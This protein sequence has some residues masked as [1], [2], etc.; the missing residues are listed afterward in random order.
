MAKGYDQNQERLAALNWLG[1]DLARR[2]KSKCELCE[3]SGTKLVPY[4]VP[5]VAK[6]P[7]LEKTLLVCEECGSQLTSDRQFRAD[8]RWRVLCTTV[9]GEL[10]AAQVVSVRLLRR[11]AKEPSTESWAYDA[12]EQ[13]YLDPAVEEW[14]DS[15]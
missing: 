14:V 8:D 3:A 15:A 2:A 1:K 7:D 13:L 10:P 11:L 5:P 12:L 9:W 4:E 6:E